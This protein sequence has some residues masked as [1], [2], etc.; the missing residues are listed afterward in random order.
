LTERLD[1]TDAEIEAVIDTVLA[2]IVTR[3]AA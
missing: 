1:V 3:P 2:G